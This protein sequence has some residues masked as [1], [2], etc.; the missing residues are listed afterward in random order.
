MAKISLDYKQNLSQQEGGENKRKFDFIYLLMGGVVIALFLGFMA[1]IFTVWGISN[2]YMRDNQNSY[3]EYTNQ[4][5]I[6]ND[7]S[8]ELIRLLQKQ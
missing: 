8:E 6:Q 3:Q 4:L 2:S 1:L 5:R 7:K